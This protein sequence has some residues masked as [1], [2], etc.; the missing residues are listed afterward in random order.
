MADNGDGWTYPRKPVYQP[1]IVDFFSFYTGGEEFDS[2]YVFSREQILQIQPNDVR[3]W[4]ANAAYN[5]PDYNVDSGDRPVYCRAS[6]LEQ[7]KKA[8][9]YFMVYRAAPW[10]NGQGNPTRSTVVNDLIK[11][12]KKFEVRGEGADGNAKRPLKQIEFLKTHELLRQQEDFNHAY[13]Y[14]MMGLWQYTLIGRVDDVCNFV[15]NDPRG[16]PDFDFALKTR[17]RWSKNVMEERTCPPQIILGAMDPRFCILLNLANYLEEYLRLFPDAKYL[18]TDKDTETAPKNLIAQYRGRLEKVVWKNQDFMALAAEDDEQGVGTHSYRKFPSNYARGCG[19]T[20]DEIEIRGRWKTQGHRVVFRYI[21][22]KQ[23]Y[24]DA[25]VCGKLCV[26]GPIKYKPKEGIVLHDEWL[27]EHVVPNLRRRFPNDSRLCKVLAHALLFAAMDP[28]LG[29]NLPPI[30]RERITHAYLG[31]YPD[32]QQPIERVPLV[33]YRIE[34]TLCIDERPVGAANAAAAN[35]GEGIEHQATNDQLAAIL[36]NQQRLEQLESQHHQQM[37]DALSSLRD[38]A[39]TKFKTI[40]NNIRRYGGTIPS[41][42]AR[43]DP[44]QQAQRRRG[45]DEEL[46]DDG[47]HP[48]TLAKTPRTLA[49]LWEEYQFGIGNRKP[50]KDFTSQ[51]RGNRRNGLKQKYYR[52]KFVWWTIEELM[53]R[54]DSRDAAI[55]KIRSAYGFRCSV[56][57]IINKLID[58]HKNGGNGHP[59]LVSLRNRLRTQATV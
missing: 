30:T 41:S 52:R 35:H 33:I 25:K 48:A 32:T 6:N 16:N 26:G 45:T 42:F 5:D 24:V 19:C 47:V 21:D 53:A 8:L 13:K 12:V 31:I 55:H 39:E 34:D 38:W 57:T 4:M 14:P 46:Q 17:V 9:S 50:A 3:R 22:V 49:E 27:F 28:D 54:G 1:Y 59:N 20:P 40:N 10:V 58:D 51:E 7:M 18:F 15:V 56:T 37:M 29:E 43:Q 44:Q 11:E 2:K 36:I 23:L